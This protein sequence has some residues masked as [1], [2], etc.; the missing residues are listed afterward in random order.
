MPAAAK[1]CIR[2]GPETGHNAL[3]RWHPSCTEALTTGYGLQH[4]SADGGHPATLPPGCWS[5][6]LG[7]IR[8]SMAFHTHH[9]CMRAVSVSHTPY[10]HT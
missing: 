10:V 6:L 8:G 7:P 4:D 1:L 3:S 2:P 5:L 9:G